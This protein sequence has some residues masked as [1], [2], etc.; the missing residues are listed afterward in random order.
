MCASDGATPGPRTPQGPG[1]VLRGKVERV[2]NAGRPIC[3]TNQGDA[4]VPTIGDMQGTGH[5]LWF[6]QLNE[7]FSV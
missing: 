5:L 2:S 7:V 4:T 6:E 1:L 3:E